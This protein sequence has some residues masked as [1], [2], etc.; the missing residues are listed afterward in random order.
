MVFLV[1]RAPSPQKTLFLFFSF[2]FDL[3]SGTMSVKG[4]EQG[5]HILINFGKLEIIQMPAEFVNI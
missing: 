2:F 5:K 1:G 4:Q 3:S